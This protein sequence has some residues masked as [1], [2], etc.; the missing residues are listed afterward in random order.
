M[1]RIGLLG[2]GRIGQ[3]HA[4]AIAA[5]SGARLVAVCDAL[6][7]A[8]AA[9]ATLHGAEVRST[10]AILSATDI[11][12]VLICTPTDTHADLI[13]A[14][15]RAGKAIFCEKPISLDL[16]RARAC[17]KVVRQTGAVLMMGFQRRF[18]P[19]FRAVKAAIDAGDIGKVEMVLITSRDPGAPPISY[20]ERSG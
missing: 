7:P 10:D 17:L 20:I 5:T 2:A 13:E 6:A 4:H 18:D 12:A 11:D 16:A 15:A 14:A 3:V 19:H 1:L 9:L 8:A